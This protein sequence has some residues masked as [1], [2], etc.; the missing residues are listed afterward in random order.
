VFAASINDNRRMLTTLPSRWAV[1]SAT[2]A[3]WALAA[4]G[5]AF[6]GL[7]LSAG[8]PQAAARA[9]AP[10]AAVP[11]DPAAIAR[12]MGGGPA[13]ASAPVA[14][15]ASR[16]Q[17]VG[18]VGQGARNGIAVLAIDG[19]PARPYRVGAAVDDALV[20]LAVEGRRAMIGPAGAQAPSLTLE[21]P[22]LRK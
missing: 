5:A 12:L 4:A 1:R 3:L 15:V 6:W 10:G 22:P 16:F 18:V 9:V 20:L 17:L 21:L 11:S 2:V 7:R 19:K 13:Q 14:S 8:G